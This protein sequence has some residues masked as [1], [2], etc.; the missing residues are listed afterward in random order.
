MNLAL[1]ASLEQRGR[2][3]VKVG[4]HEFL[5]MGIHYE[6]SPAYVLVYM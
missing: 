5:D 6:I 4:V 1:K 3:L 2:K